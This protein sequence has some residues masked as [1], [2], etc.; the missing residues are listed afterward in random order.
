[1][2][3]T[4]SITVFLSFLLVLVTNADEFRIWT[5]AGGKSTV[6]AKLV[7]IAEDGNTVTLQ[8]T[9]GKKGKFELEKFSKEDQE[10]VRK[11]QQEEQDQVQFTDA[12]QTEIDK[13]C[14]KFGNNVNVVNKDGRTLLHLASVSYLDGKRM[15]DWD[16]V[17]YKFLISQRIGVNEK[18]NSG[19]IPLHLAVFW[20]K[21]IDVIK[22]LVSQGAD[23]NANSC[24]KTSL[25]F[26]AEKGNIEIVKFLIS[27]GADVNAKD[28]EGYT[29]LDAAQKH[30][31][32][33][34]YLASKGGISG[35]QEKTKPLRVTQNVDNRVTE[36]KS[37]FSNSEYKP[38][39]YRRLPKGPRGRAILQREQ[40][41]REVYRKTSIG[42]TFNEVRSVLGQPTWGNINYSMGGVSGTA[43]FKK[44]S[45][46]KVYHF[47]TDGR[48][49]SI[50]DFV[51]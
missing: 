9:G 21:N 8:R 37:D 32:V 6:E 47:G 25:H 11:S 33:I 49:Q 41:A 39:D 12:E 20:N 35:I 19:F 44:G 46:T 15:P 4:V 31:T 28:N 13:F 5:S 14:M 17:V 22:Y 36:S 18:D 2:K 29:P 40:L 51:N 34:E 30:K 7:A 50:T 23:V 1:M 45:I 26:A 27:K 38:R 24:G 16:I 48:V 42:A 10:F 3:K 43:F